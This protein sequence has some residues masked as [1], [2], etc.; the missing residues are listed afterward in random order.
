MDYTKGSKVELWAFFP[1]MPTDPLLL[2]KF[3]KQKLA[4]NSSSA[5][6]VNLSTGVE[7][8]CADP[9]TVDLKIQADQ[10][11]ELNLVYPGNLTKVSTGAYKYIFDSA[12]YEGE[13]RY[14]FT[15]EESSTEGVF[16]VVTVLQ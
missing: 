10:G 13:V 14:K 15:S 1:V 6:V 7:V 16:N 3:L 4:Y 2:K 11:V 9:L 5:K 12:D 8:I